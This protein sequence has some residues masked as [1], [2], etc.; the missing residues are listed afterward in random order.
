MIENYLFQKVK[1]ISFDFS[2]DVNARQSDRYL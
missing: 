2:L 1:Q